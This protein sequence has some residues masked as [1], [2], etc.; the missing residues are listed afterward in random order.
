MKIFLSRLFRWSWIV[1]LPFVV[2]G[3]FVSYRAIDRFY[4]FTMRY[5][6]SPF[7]ISLVTS[8]HYEI[9]AL[10][11]KFNVGLSNFQY[12]QNL[13]TIE[14]FV[15][16]ANISQLE[17]HLPQSGFEYVKARVLIDDR[18]V[19]AKVKY[20]GDFLPHWAWDKKS[21]RVKTDKN[22]LLNGIRTFNLQAPK[23]AE[24]LNN[25][26]ALKLAKALHLIAP[27]SRL[28]TLTVN[29]KNLGLYIFV[30][31]LREE[32]LRRQNFMPADIYRGELLGKDKFVDSG[33]NTL[34][35][36]P[37]VWD[38]MSINNHYP[39]NSMA[40]LT[41]LLEL[42]GEIDSSSFETD[43]ENLIANQKAF[44]EIMDLQA[45]AAFSVF[46]TLAQ[47]RHFDAKHNWRLYY[48]P[49][50]QKFLP[51][52]W[53]PGGW[54][55]T[56]RAPEGTQVSAYVI[57]TALHRV[58]FRDGSFI[59]NRNQILHNFFGNGDSA[60][61]LKELE[62][63][64]AQVRNNLDHD[65][66]LR[67]P[68]PK[69]ANAA[70]DSL[71]TYIRRTFSEIEAQLQVRDKPVQ[72]WIEKG[73]VKLAVQNLNPVRSIRLVYA[74]PLTDDVVVFISYTDHMGKHTFRIPVSMQPDSMHI[75]IQTGLV[76]ELEGSYN[77]GDVFPLV[78]AFPAIYELDIQGVGTL[79]PQQILVDQGNGL[80]DVEIGETFK[81]E[82]VVSEATQKKID[83]I[84]L[85]SWQVFWD[86]GH[87]FNAINSS[88]IASLKPSP[89]P[90]ASPNQE[91]SPNNE[92][93]P[94]PISSKKRT[95]W[96]FTKRIPAGTNALRVDLPP[97][98]KSLVSNIRLLSARENFPVPVE[99]L[100]LNMMQAEDRGIRATGDQDPYMSF[101]INEIIGRVPDYAQSI[102]LEFDL[103]VHSPFTRYNEKLL[104]GT[105]G[106]LNAIY[107]PVHLPTNLD[108][109]E[110]QGEVTI[111][112]S[113]TV[114]Q[115]LTIKPGT[116]LLMGPGASLILRNRLTAE[117]TA[118]NPITIK[119]LNPGQ[120]PWGTIALI[121]KDA[122]HSSFKHCIFDG[123]S[124]AKGPLFEYTAML[125]I[126]DLKNVLVEDC[127]FSNSKITDDMVHVVYSDVRFTRTRFINANLDALDIDMSKVLI[128]DS[129]FQNSGNDA[130]DL[131][132]SYAE[133]YRTSLQNNGDKGISVGENSQL[134]GVELD[135]SKNLIGLQ[136]K[137]ASQVVLYNS[138]L[139]GNTKALDAYKKNWRYDRGGSIY[140][141]KTSI[142]DNKSSISTGVRSRINLFD[143]FLDRAPN[144]KSEKGNIKLEQVDSLHSDAVTQALYGEDQGSPET[145][146]L[147]RN[148]PESFTSRISIES[149]GSSSYAN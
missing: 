149:R 81:P 135:I 26:L 25:L 54:P 38:K 73:K 100:S 97:Y 33:I 137:D 146:E 106:K 40:P 43:A 77:S 110:W 112:D 78:I 9:D 91:D 19:K 74:S 144:S 105:L 103:N 41:R 79:L 64:V 14:L 124:G 136:S 108:V 58:L 52:A 87:G 61:Y 48:D 115:P 46:E 2:L 68:K 1:T 102:T 134:L 84:G 45:W 13:E 66:H 42:I 122:S 142:K 20:R 71:E 60:N 95:R 32:T 55:R 44:A 94:D 57:S 138:S 132:T 130:I 24:Q 85:Q 69:T 63:I 39:E 111:R 80:N 92:A 131:M 133:V 30:E 5:D 98:S 96:H 116:S 16:Q 93:S 49:W 4:N 22:R 125:S 51:V 121:G 65:P 76:A 126:H 109:L 50:R 99:K 59:R 113:R 120:E 82:L 107:N 53:D 90:E 145:R 56:W 47:T 35:E 129:L 6:P 3:T 88:N 62:S 67:P 70:L 127:T 7:Y 27:E 143:S 11:H 147:L 10:V 118:E 36:T 140:V 101:R 83:N 141:A 37:A 23:A 28:V 139:T 31:Q 119:A 8:A 117:G 114:N 89:G 128:E 12:Q 17:S 86:T 21:W 18:L 29:R 75:T 104:D 72:A 148:L 15:P 34:F 123:G